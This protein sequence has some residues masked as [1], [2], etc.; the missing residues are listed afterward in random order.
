MSNV[1]WNE[2][3]RYEMDNILAKGTVA[4]I[5]VLAM[6]SIAVIIISSMIVTIFGL[7][8]DYGLIDMMWMALMRTL[9]AGT[10]GGDTGSWSFKFMM[11]AVTIGGIFI[12][13]TLIGVLSSGLDDRL[14]EMRKGKSKVV[15]RNHTVILGWG[16]QIYTVIAELI[17]ANI[18]L[19][20]AC[21]VVMSDLDA[22]EMQELL[23]IH[24]PER[25][26][27]RI[28]VR[29]GNPS[30]STAL[31]MVNLPDAKSIIVIRPEQDDPDMAVI[32]ILL[33][34][35]NDNQR[36]TSPYHIVAEIN[37]PKNIAVARIISRDEIELIATGELIARITAQ[38]CRQ[39]GL[40]I[41]YTDL[42]DFGGDEIYF[43]AFPELSGQ[44][45]AQVALAFD[46]ASVIGVVH[47][48]NSMH[49]NPSS[50][51]IIGADD[52]LI[53]IAADDSAIHMT[54]APTEPL[55]IDAITKKPR[56]RA[57][58]EKTLILG[59]N[60][61]TALVV[62]DLD[63]Y[64]SAGSHVTIVCDRMF[65]TIQQWQTANTLKN[66]SVTVLNQDTTDRDVLD[67]LAL[68]TFDHIIV[69][70]MSDVLSVD[71]SDAATLMTLLHLRDIS[72]RTKHRFS[73]VSEMLDI[74]NRRLADATRADDF[75]V[76][77][78]LVSLIVAQVAE[79]KQLN[80]LFT[81][82]FDPDG[83]EIYLKPVSHYVK[84]GVAVNHATLV[85]A[86][87][88]R[89]E[90]AIG[91]RIHAKSYD[92]NANYGIVLNPNKAHTVTFADDDRIIVIAPK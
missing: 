35:V 40:S 88:K 91:Y 5:G 80:A 21:I 36:R 84:P 53:F 48:D 8:P 19:K 28:V 16:P 65:D 78:R 32:K 44:S 66:S 92:T 1:S 54:S 13:S 56:S 10:M 70:A 27:T 20:Y 81:D 86:A 18:S 2:K 7:S 89:N 72:D 43:K 77:N 12:V 47:A 45:F 73:I 79:N 68:H 67:N 90:V 57:T 42:L 25:H 46:T 30:D 64:V 49:L 50:T 85:A 22:I 69:M 51:T 33:A 71:A 11:L 61:R 75:I 52:Q 9:D 37:D 58:P 15:E 76:S 29:N 74:R 60:W 63:S 34:V 31:Q 82:L 41:V 6:A 38:T 3:L 59:W 23:S 4:L 14:A 62:R 26:S 55:N 83:S 39:S 24:V 87:Q 17:E